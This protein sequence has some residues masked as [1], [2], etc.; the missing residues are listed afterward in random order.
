M[1]SF[2]TSTRG[3]VSSGGSGLTGANAMLENARGV[4]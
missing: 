1:I 3:R 2:A 4:I